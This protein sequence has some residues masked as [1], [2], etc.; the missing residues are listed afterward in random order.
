MME[1]DI[2]EYIYSLLPADAKETSGGWIT[3]NC[4]SC[5]RVEGTGV[6]DTRRRGGMKIDGTGFVYNCFNCKFKVGYH[7][8]DYLS[9]NAKQL[10]I[11]LGCSHDQIMKLN[12]LA[13]KNLSGEN[14]EKVSEVKRKYYKLPFYYN[15]ILTTSKDLQGTENFKESIEY[16]Y[17]RNPNVF[18]WRD[19]YWTAQE[20]AIAFK[21][22]EHQQE[23]G[24]IKRYYGKN[25]KI[26]YEN[27]IPSGH[28]FNFDLID[29]N[30]KYQI[31]TEG[32]FDAISLNCFG[33]LGNDITKEKLNYIKMIS[34]RFKLI[35]LP[36]RDIAGFKVV[37][38]LYD[39][40]VD[41]GFAF[42]ENWDKNIKDGFDAVYKYGR[43]K[44]IQDIIKSA[45]FNKTSAMIKACN[46]CGCDLHGEAR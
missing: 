4:Q 46:W 32:V 35:Y 29:T 39:E 16:L 25:A 34:N 23:V 33:L 20:K 12:M 5:G 3:W 10:F 8:G 27:L 17:K 28:I 7:I 41:V 24:Y 21:C 30:R 14:K 1:E 36:D 44:S 15:N 40:S 9:R 45:D 42:P 13:M 26:K 31:L 6:N 37:K 19:F 38:K 18:Y 2:I 11:D 22:F 43:L